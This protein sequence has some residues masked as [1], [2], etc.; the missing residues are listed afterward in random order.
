MTEHSVILKNKWELQNSEFEVLLCFA[1]VTVAVGLCFLPGVPGLTTR[2]IINNETCG[3][4]WKK[5]KLCNWI[6]QLPDISHSYL[7][8]PTSFFHIHDEFS[9]IEPLKFASS[10]WYFGWQDYC[11]CLVLVQ[12]VLLQH[13]FCPQKSTQMSGARSLVPSQPKSPPWNALG[14]LQKMSDSFPAESDHQQT[15]LAPVPLVFKRGGHLFPR[16]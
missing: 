6:S 8:I 7:K 5:I 9:I 1:F 2:E 11:P 10:H 16:V 3:H 13:L 12:N 4:L 14:S 15:W